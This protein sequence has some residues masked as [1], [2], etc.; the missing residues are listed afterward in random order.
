MRVLVTGSVG[1]IGQAT[2]THL[3]ERGYDVRQIDIASPQ[4]SHGVDY[5][6]CDITDFSALC[7]HMQGCD[8]VVH[9]A[10]IRS[11]MFA[12]AHEVYRVNTVGTFNVFEAAAQE[13]IRR[14]AQASSINAFGCGWMTTDFRPQYFPIDEDHPSFTTDPYAFS[15]QQVEE[16]GAY[17][18]RRDKISSVAFRFPGVHPAGDYHSPQFN[19]RRDAECAFINRFLQHSESEQQRQ[20]TEV[21]RHCLALRA[22]RKLEYPYTTW[23]IPAPAGVDEGLWRAY[24]FD[25]YHLWTSIDVRDAAQA[26]EKSLIAEFEDAH[27]LFVNDAHNLLDYDSHTLARLFFPD[28]TLW[29]SPVPGSG[30][31]VS[32]NRAR[33]LIGFEPQYSAHRGD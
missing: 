32:F 27:P 5:R 19:E 9:L 31:L 6:Q 28:V 12:P 4:D 18:W 8:A 7:E 22:E 25:R 10:A 24:T 26:I 2:A 16:I 29:K 23:A 11:P 20:L 3:L 1:L 21:R 17:F 30:S 33:D 15:K 14:I 13:G